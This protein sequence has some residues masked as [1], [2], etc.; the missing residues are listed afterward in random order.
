MTIMKK[1]EMQ[2]IY[3]DL[4]KSEEDLLKDLMSKKMAEEEREKA[5]RIQV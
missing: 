4:V 2:K 1:E 3:R 5:K